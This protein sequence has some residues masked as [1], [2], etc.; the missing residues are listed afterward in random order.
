MDNQGTHTHRTQQERD[1]WRAGF[2]AG[3]D[4]AAG[5]IL[6]FAPQSD[7][8]VTQGL[9]RALRELYD[10]VLLEVAYNSDSHPGP[11]QPDPLD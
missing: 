3:M 5:V 6:D 9:A 2:L 8:E 10:A 4:A 1:A 11:D 7:P